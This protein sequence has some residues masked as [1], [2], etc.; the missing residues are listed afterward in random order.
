M[1]AKVENIPLSLARERLETSARSQA[2]PMR[3]KQPMGSWRIR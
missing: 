1:G 2:I 3:P